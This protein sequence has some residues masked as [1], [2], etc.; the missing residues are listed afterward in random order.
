ML[1]I[2]A[3]GKRLHLP[4]DISVDMTWENPF[5]MQDRIP[6]PYSMSFILPPTKDNLQIAGNVNRIA[7]AG[8]WSEMDSRISFNQVNILTGKLFLQ[9]SEKNLKFNFV[10]SLLSDL[11]KERMD[12][13][14][15][16]LNS[17]GTGYSSIDDFDDDWPL[18]YKQTIDAN[19]KDIGVKYAAC[20]VRLT[21]KSW[22]R[23]ELL[24]GFWNAHRLYLNMWN[25]DAGSFIFTDVSEPV[26]HGAIYP[27]PYIHYLIDLVFGT[28]INT[29]FFKND[30]ELKK[31]CMVTSYHKM[32]TEAEYFTASMRGVLID[33]YTLGLLPRYFYLS[34]YFNRYSFSSFLKNILK[35]FCCSLLPRPDGKWDIIHNKAIIDSTDIVDWSTKLAGIPAIG[36]QK[37][38]HYAYGYSGESE[39][40]ENGGYATVDS[41]EDMIASAVETRYFISTTK[42]IYDK[43]LR[44]E[45][46]PGVYDYDRVKTGLASLENPESGEDGNETYPMESEVTAVKMRPDEYWWLN[47]GGSRL[48]WYVPEFSGDRFSNDFAP[49]IGFMRGFYNV[50]TKQI[51][52]AP[53][54]YSDHYPLL[55]PYNY[56]PGGNRTGDYSLAWEGA[57][58][59]ITKFHSDYKAY[60]EG[61]H[62]TLK[63]LFNLSH[64]DLK[65]LDYKKKIY[66]RGKKYYIKKIETTIRKRSLSLS[67]CELIEA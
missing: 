42:E 66:V 21:A 34:S 56:D 65:N 62:T 16:D 54:D 59:L 57:D 5:L 46:I 44:D 53:A 23:D 45:E 55:T 25:V 36:M 47:S 10:G 41:I 6:A 11:V 32:F 63:A 18:T 15:V 33:D 52:S 38:R 48:P 43:K 22:E 8:Q 35:I 58:G 4:D 2:Y 29:N 20:P 24:Y 13:M 50:V 39:T 61:E 49:Q 37:A 51:D 19:L 40:I 26:M 28:A 14:D 3:N 60:I 27:Q 7:A 1:E 9:E 67:R 31:L 17:F 12:R 30:A 64:L